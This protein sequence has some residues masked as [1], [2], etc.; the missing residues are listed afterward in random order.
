MST[1]TD[2]E[3]LTMGGW[4][5]GV[6][7]RA[8]ETE[9]VL[10]RDERKIP[11]SQFLRKALNVDFTA[12]GH[13][14][15]RRGYIL[16]AAGFSHSIWSTDRL[17]LI[18]W[19]R[20]GGLFVGREVTDAVSIRAV[21]KYLPMSFC[22]VN[23]TVYY[24]N[25]SE[26]GEIS[27]DGTARNWGITIPPAPTLS[28]PATEDPGGW[29][30]TR[31][32]A[33]TYID[34]SG[35]ESG[36]S[37]PVLVGAAGTFTVDTPLPLPAGVASAQVYVSQI[38][39]EILYHAQTMI[40]TSPITIHDNDVGVGKELETLD[41]YPPKAGQLVAHMNGRVYIARNDYVSFSEPLRPDLFRPSQGIYTF[42]DTVTMLEPSTDGV[43]VGHSKG[44][45]F[46]AGADP[47][48]VQ[49][50]HVSP[51][52]PV[53]GAV[54]RVPGEKFGVGV[55]EVPVWWGKDGVMVVGLPG[56][57]LRQLTRDRLAVPAHAAG[58]VTLREHDGMS[59][60]VSS[61]RLGDGDN[62][63]GASD[64]VVAEVRRNNISL[65]T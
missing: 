39:S 27:Y 61:L 36:A 33:I 24:S 1:P 20:D 14:I 49:Q 25:G 38:N 10:M 59:H 42:P 12:E 30:N 37:E 48:D 28:G 53:T 55:D 29:D 4:P 23:D 43:Y 5:G 46:I 64:T 3:L 22:H 52:A 35:R 32:V 17:G 45:V 18:C 57:Q 44:V 19:V 16:A 63:M 40:A 2:A 56:G 6:N 9:Q 31:Q 62:P 51:Y 50:I 7:N 26:L 41:R 65:N 58:A 13:P 11:S 15:R 54:S 21:N 60:I 8:R 34:A 47:Y